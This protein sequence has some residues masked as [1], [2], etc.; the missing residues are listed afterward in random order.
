MEEWDRFF[1]GVCLALPDFLFT[2]GR[3]FST[4]RNR[5]KTHTIQHERCK[6]LFVSHFKWKRKAGYV[7]TD[8][9]KR[10]KSGLKDSP[11]TSTLLQRL[12]C[13]PHTEHNSQSMAV[14]AEN[15]EW[16]SRETRFVLSCSNSKSQDSNR[17]INLWRQ[18]VLTWKTALWRTGFQRK[19]CQDGYPLVHHWISSMP[20]QI[21]VSYAATFLANQILDLFYFQSQNPK[22]TKNN[23]NCS[24]KASETWRA[25]L[26]EVKRKF[27][28]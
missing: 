22:Q 23:S 12:H 15:K 1:L 7:N 13:K 8:M 10:L 5:A 27:P 28:S 3:C 17:E 4:L 25:K 11:P 20:Q 2:L 26:P 6:F 18:K 14:N 19:S 24:M 16:S 21:T 9:T